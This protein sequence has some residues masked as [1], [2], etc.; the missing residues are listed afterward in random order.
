MSFG[1]F[2]VLFGLLSCQNPRQST[3]RIAVS[4][5]AEPLASSLMR[6]FTKDSTLILETFLGSSGQLS[7]KIANGAPYDIFLA[8]DTTYPE[9]LFSEGFGQSAPKVYARGILVMMTTDRQLSTDQL[10]SAAV[11]RIAIAN[12]DLAPYGKATKEYLERMNLWDSLQPKFVYAEN[13]LQ[14][15]LYTTTKAV[16][17]GFGALSIAKNLSAKTALDYRRLDSSFYRP[18]NQAALLLERPGQPT[19]VKAFYDFI[20]SPVG[21]S[22]IEDH[23]YRL[24]N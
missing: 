9:Y 21:Q 13:A 5:N 19:E 24:L 7:A 11:K 23:G 8:A 22:I 17:V 10:T 16:D 6:A 3:I 14:A 20:F 2:V 4:A 15:G 1:L 18:I 12:P